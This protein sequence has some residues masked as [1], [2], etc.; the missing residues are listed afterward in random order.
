MN[1]NPAAE[2]APVK[3]IKGF[4]AKLQCKDFQF[5][6]GATF[7]HEGEVI[8]CKSGFH[9]IHE[10]Q[11]P[12]AVFQYYAPATSRYCLVE[13]DGQTVR[14]EDKIAAK[15]LTV[16]REIGLRELT[17][18]A[19]RWV[20]DRAKPEGAATASGTQ[21]AATA[22]GTRG[23]ATA[24]GTQGAATASG[25]QGAATASGARGAATASGTQGAATASGARG[26]ATA[27][28]DQGRVRGVAGNALFAV[29]RDSYGS[30]ASVACGIVGQNEI[31][32]DVWYACKGGKLVEI[33]DCP[34]PKSA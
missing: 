26:A 14:K 27:S 13:V 11:H 19:V 33:L 16:G 34:S 23:A 21:G 29:E 24:S 4:N 9:A 10:D 7:K 18:E 17:L 8:A 5:E 22:S 2:E 25:T 3:A 6:I 20:T 30:I 15:I 31:S 32:P 12:L 28:G 1:A